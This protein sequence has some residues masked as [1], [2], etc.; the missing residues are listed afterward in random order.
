LSRRTPLRDLAGMDCN[1][2][3]LG[4]YLPLA[5]GVSSVRY[6]IRQRTFTYVGTVQS[7]TDETCHEPTSASAVLLRA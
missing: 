4:G 5:H 3:E 2:A 7:V 1:P 6:P